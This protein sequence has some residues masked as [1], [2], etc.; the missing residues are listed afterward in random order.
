MIYLTIGLLIA[1]GAAIV[2][3]N[4]LM[5]Q[6]SGGASSPL[7]ALLINSAVGFVLLFMLLVGRSGPAGIIETLS[8]LRLWHVLPGLLGSLFVFAS[9]QGYQRPVLRPRRPF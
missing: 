2:A 7:V 5:V 4:L 8:G 1:A 9:L 6:I 3:Q